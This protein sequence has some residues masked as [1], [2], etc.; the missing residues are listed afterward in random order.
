M[1]D[2]KRP[3]QD[4]AFVFF[5]QLFGIAKRLL[6]P[7]LVEGAAGILLELQAERRH[8]VERGVEF[9]KF[10]EDL[11]HAPVILQGMQAGPR[12]D[13]A[14]GFRIAVLRLVHVPENDQMNLVHREKRSG[15]ATT[16]ASTGAVL[17]SRFAPCAFLTAIS[18]VKF[19]VMHSSDLSSSHSYFL[20][21]NWFGSW[22]SWFAIPDQARRSQNSFFTFFPAYSFSRF[23][24][25]CSSLSCWASAAFPRPAK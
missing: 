7:R 20:C 4:F 18:S 25:R 3:L 17:H 16:S 14:P 1:V 5:G 13:V 24:W 21:R 6:E 23:R 12:Q 22:S 8:D 2:L 10:L 9:R 19:S 11:H 15:G